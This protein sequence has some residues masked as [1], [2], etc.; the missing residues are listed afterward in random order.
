MLEW[1]GVSNPIGT[2][3]GSGCEQVCMRWRSWRC[4]RMIKGRSQTHTLN[5]QSH[6]D[7]YAFSISLDESLD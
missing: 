6:A 2:G 1:N 3:T 5:M 4:A 7:H